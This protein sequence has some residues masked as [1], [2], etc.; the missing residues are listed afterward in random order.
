[1]AAGA[2]RRVARDDPLDRTILPPRAT[3]GWIGRDIAQTIPMKSN[4]A[5]ASAN[6]C[7]P[8]V[9]NPMFARNSPS[10]SML[11]FGSTES[12]RAPPSD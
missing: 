12:Q 10:F 1:M 8:G 3:F 5:P 2:A 6:D 9:T 4:T 11:P 7:W